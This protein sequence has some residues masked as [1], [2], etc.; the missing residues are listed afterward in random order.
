MD[1]RFFIDQFNF[2]E[3]EDFFLRG[4]P[5]LV[6]LWTFLDQESIF[7]AKMDFSLA[8]VDVFLDQ[9]VFFWTSRTII[10]QYYLGT[11]I[12]QGEVNGKGKRGARKRKP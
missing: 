9:E 12:G 10:G 6:Q 8:Q 1:Q 4:G 3:Q 7:L 11:R 2:L 5:F